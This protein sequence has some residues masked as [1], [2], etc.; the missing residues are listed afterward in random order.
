VRP[1]LAAA[2]GLY[3]LVVI[4]LAAGL[5]AV[6]PVRFGVDLTATAWADRGV[7][8]LGVCV[9]GALVIGLSSGLAAR[10]PELRG[11]LL[12]L[13]AVTLLFL[14]VELALVYGSFTG[15]LPADYATPGSD[16]AFVQ[17]AQSA[18][19]TSPW[20]PVLVTCHLAYV[21]AWAARVLTRRGAPGARQHGVSRGTADS[22]A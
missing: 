8:V 11:E 3:A 7:F 4:L 9:L 6:V 22:A 14:A 1:V 18:V 2:S 10:T 16:A 5:P 15:S 19:R 13:G 20:A 12:R 21:L 17:R